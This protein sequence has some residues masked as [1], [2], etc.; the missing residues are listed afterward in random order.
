MGPGWDR[1]WDVFGHRL[2]G[3]EVAGGGAVAAGQ[4]QGRGTAPGA[5]R[6]GVVVPFW[7]RSGAV[8]RDSASLP[9]G[10]AVDDLHGVIMNKLLLSPAEAAEVLGIGR[11]K[12]YELLSAGIIRSVHIGRGR[13]VPTEALLEYVRDLQGSTV[14]DL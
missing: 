13:R 3:R 7:C 12:L 11:T 2:V 14:G 4:R 10:V 1:G 5:V 8:S 9:V 6:A